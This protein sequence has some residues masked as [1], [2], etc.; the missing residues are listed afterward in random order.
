MEL[1]I[2]RFDS[3]DSTNSEAMR[4][5]RLG[6][7]EGLWITANEQTAGRGRQGREWVSRAGQGIYASVVLRPALEAAYLP[8]IT[9]AAAVAVHDT[10]AKLGLAPRHKVAERHFGRRTKDRRHSR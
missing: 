6:A 3:I 9:L 10:L 4:Q 7:A 1:T 8:L 2:L 5:A